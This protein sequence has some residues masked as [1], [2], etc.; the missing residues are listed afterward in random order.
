M[1]LF[2]TKINDIQ[3]HI[4]ALQAEAAK[5]QDLENATASS[6]ANLKAVVANI[7]GDEAAIATLKSAIMDLFPKEDRYI[8]GDCGNSFPDSE[9]VEGEDFCVNCGESESDSQAVEDEDEENPSP[10]NKQEPEFGTAEKPCPATLTGECANPECEGETFTCE[11]CGKEISYCFGGDGDE[12]C[13]DCWSKCKPDEIETTDEVREKIQHVKELQEEKLIEDSSPENKPEFKK[14]FEGEPEPDESGY[15]F[16]SEQV[17]R[18]ENLLNIHFKLKREANSWADLFKFKYHD[19]HTEV[20]K[21]RHDG[22]S[23]ILEVTKNNSN[24][25]QWW[26]EVTSFDYSLTPEENSRREKYHLLIQKNQGS[27]MVEIEAT[28]EVLARKNYQH[29]IESIPDA[30]ISLMSNKRGCIESHKP[31]VQQTL[32][33][34]KPRKL[35]K[36]EIWCPECDG[37]GEVPYTEMIDGIT[38]ERPVKCPKCNGEA[39][40]AQIKPLPSDVLDEDDEPAFSFMGTSISQNVICDGEV[41]GTIYPNQSGWEL[42]NGDVFAT[43][44]EAAHALFNSSS[45]AA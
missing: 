9:M 27:E 41:I 29:L 37:Q 25:S 28:D 44:E 21:Y 13:N 1:Q 15:V 3:S 24:D 5:L 38:E 35:E 45:T 11:G 39:I 40:I 12:L 19:C 30:F 32:P 22:F 7:E 36:N 17:Y 10:G 8:C 42:E 20:R 23:Y 43:R 34:A 18:S 4:E 6:L 16:Y 14:A 31:A 2:T 33:E 26:E